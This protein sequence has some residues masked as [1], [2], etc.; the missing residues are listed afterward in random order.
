[1]PFRQASG[2]SFFQFNSLNQPEVVHAVFTRRGGVSPRPWRSLNLGGTVGDD[3]QRVAENRVRLLEAAGRP[4]ESSFD[5]WQVH[6][7]R[8]VQALAPRGAQPPQKADGIVTDRPEVTLV[9]RFADCVPVLAFDPVRRA[10]GIAHAGWKGTVHNVSAG[11]VGQ[12]TRAFGSRPQDLQVGIGPSIGPD[13]YPIGPDVI[14][15]VRNVFGRHAD[16]H[17]QAANGSLHFDLWSANRWQLEQAGVQS[18]EVAGICT[19]CS[20]GDWFSHR[21]EAGK[22]GRFGAILGLNA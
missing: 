19:A 14:E 20:T 7:A 6:S 4:V 17:L 2:L 5:V 13:H 3:P 8:V 21:G 18:V 11:L 9:M 10:I 16:E 15:Q 12:M 22:T 1:M